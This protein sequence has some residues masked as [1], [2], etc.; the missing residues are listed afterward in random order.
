[1]VFRPPRRPSVS[2]R[3]SPPPV[4]DFIPGVLQPAAGP[5]LG[6]VDLDLHLHRLDHSLHLASPHSFESWWGKTTR[7]PSTPFCDTC[8]LL[9]LSLRRRKRQGQQKTGR[10]SQAWLRAPKLA[11]PRARTTFLLQPREWRG[12]L[13]PSPT[14]PPCP[15]SLSTPRPTMIWTSR[16]SAAHGPSVSAPPKRYRRRSNLRLHR[17]SR[18]ERAQQRRSMAPSRR[19]RNPNS[20]ASLRCPTASRRDCADDVQRGQKR[21]TRSRQITQ[22]R[23]LIRLAPHWGASSLKRGLGRQP[24]RGTSS[25]AVSALVGARRSSSW[26]A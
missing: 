3:H 13:R 24:R 14:R 5:R 20:N 26:A 9:P 25:S 12:L 7:R 21:L 15:A 10:R 6:A 23:A 4:P 18:K 2:P 8:P 1:M 17:Y 22:R 11:P 19:E 16:T